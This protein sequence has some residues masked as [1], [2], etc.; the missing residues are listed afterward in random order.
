MPSSIRSSAAFNSATAGS[1]SSAMTISST[2]SFLY[3]H[4]VPPISNPNPE[5]GVGRAEHRDHLCE[6]QASPRAVAESDDDR[7]GG[8]TPPSSGKSEI[9]VTD[10]ILRMLLEQ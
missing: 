2:L 8:A 10:L 6:L 5:F 9:L 1:A 7:S 3:E 4:L